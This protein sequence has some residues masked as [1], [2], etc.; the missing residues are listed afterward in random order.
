[1]FPPVAL[2]KDLSETII[3]DWCKNSK[4]SSLEEAGC[5]V[6][7]ELVPIIQLSDLKPVK[8]MLGVLGAAGVTR[9]EHKS[10]SQKISEFKG[11]V[12]DYQC[13][14]ICNTCCQSIRK[15]KVP[16]L[17]LANNLWLSSV[18][19]VLSDLNFIE[20]ILHQENPTSTY[21]AYGLLILLTGRN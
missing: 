7:G 15:G 2:T 18:P 11:P 13:D 3:A 6:C 8:T 21:Y 16:Q 12:F 14:K 19:K 1:M 20:R 10:A 4:L 9:V 17:A 5:A